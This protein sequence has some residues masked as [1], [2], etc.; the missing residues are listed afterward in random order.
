[1]YQDNPSLLYSSKNSN[2]VTRFTQ[3]NHYFQTVV[4]YISIHPSK[5]LPEIL[6]NVVIN[7]AI[8]YNQHYADSTIT[9]V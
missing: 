1:M 5:Y 9:C 6:T 3:V 2:Y 4:S 8:W 7:T